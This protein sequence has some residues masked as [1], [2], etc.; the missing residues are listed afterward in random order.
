MFV[1]FVSRHEICLLWAKLVTVMT[2]IVIHIK[3][4]VKIRCPLVAIQI[5]DVVVY[6][7]FLVRVKYLKRLIMF[8]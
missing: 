1:V 8:Y 3:I 4:K 2:Q 5:S 6:L 7:L